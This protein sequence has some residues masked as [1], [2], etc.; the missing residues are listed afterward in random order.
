MPNNPLKRLLRDLPKKPPLLKNILIIS[1]MLK[2]IIS[3]DVIS[4]DRLL[5]TGILGG[6]V[7]FVLL[8]F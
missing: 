2:H 8:F 7:F 6:L 3:I 5:L 4:K 1:K